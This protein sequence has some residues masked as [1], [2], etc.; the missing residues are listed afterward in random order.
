MLCGDHASFVIKLVCFSY[1]SPL[2]KSYVLFLNNIYLK[3]KDTSG[4]YLLRLV[5]AT[6]DQHHFWAR[7]WGIYFAAIACY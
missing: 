3:P 6:N 7:N 5:L 2:P 4:C 1:S